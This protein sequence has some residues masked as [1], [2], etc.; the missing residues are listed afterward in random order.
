[1]GRQ[2]I[3]HNEVGRLLSHTHHNYGLVRLCTNCPHHLTMTQGEDRV[4]TNSLKFWV[5]LTFGDIKVS[6]VVSFDRVWP[7]MVTDAPVLIGAK[8]VYAFHHDGYEPTSK[9]ASC[10]ITCVTQQ[11]NVR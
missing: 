4:A 2:E 5:S 3:S 9:V 10:F 6:T 1:M 8:F 11:V 7:I